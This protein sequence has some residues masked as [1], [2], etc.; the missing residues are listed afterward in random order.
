MMIDIKNLSKTYKSGSE[1]I[2]ILHN[3][4]LQVKEGEIL[5][6]LGRSGSGKSTLLSIVGG[7]ENFDQGQVHVN[8]QQLEKMDDK[9]KTAFRAANV[10]FVF[11]QYHL[12]PHLNAYEN[13]CLPL[14]MREKKIEINYIDDI[15]KELG[16][17]ERKN[18]KPSQ[19]SG[20]ENQRV[21]I[22]RALA[23]QPKILLADEPSASLDVETGRKVMDLFF[24]AV[25]QHKMTTILVTHDEAIA[26]RCDRV[27][28]LEA[29][30]LN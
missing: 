14:W 11:Q 4:N 28:R 16:L 3:L 17:S 9:A 29:G 20:G 7:L 8:N 10:S 13:V 26:A 6:I 18:H 15:L 30:K 5:G 27:L 19:M 2:G 1:S 25:R 24:Q 12:V 23:S 21:T 22:A